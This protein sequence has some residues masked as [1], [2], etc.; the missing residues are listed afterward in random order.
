MDELISRAANRDNSAPDDYEESGIRMC[1]KCHEPKQAFVVLPGLG[2]T[3]VPTTCKC[4]RE[5]EERR[6]AAQMQKDFC[7]GMERLQALYEISD[8]TYRRSTFGMDDMHNAKI[9]E[10]CRRYVDHWTE[11]KADNIGIL[12]YGT[13][14]TGKT[15]LS[16]AIVNA[17]LERLVPATVTNFSRLLNILQNTR[18]RQACIDH[19][20]AYHL[21][22]IDD[23]GIERDSSYAA[24][25]VFNVIDS[26]AR[27][28]LPL[29]ITT[30]LT[31]DD[32]KNPPSMQYARIYDRVLELCPITLKM[33]GESQR[34]KNAASRV[35]KAKQILG[36]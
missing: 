23:L 15:F 4:E 21:L 18:E 28:R 3:L 16:C 26:R 12:F 5:A 30:N 7:G 2:N 22:V 33:T 34:A 29:I 24:E 11:M 14:G 27:A 13:V 19:L 10:V 6:K 32:L 36:A 17:L 25:Q 9:S 20:Q 1:G 35:A 8:Y 31:M